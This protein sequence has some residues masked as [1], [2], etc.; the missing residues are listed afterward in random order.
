MILNHL[1]LIIQRVSPLS[2]GSDKFNKFSHY[3][4]L[5]R[6]SLQYII[7]ILSIYLFVISHSSLSIRSN[8]IHALE[9]KV[10]TRRQEKNSS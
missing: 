7:Y 3:Y 8:T 9:V 1:V 10:V 2:I 6:I 4:L 5:N